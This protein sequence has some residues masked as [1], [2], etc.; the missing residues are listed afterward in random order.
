M[1]RWLCQPSRS[2]ASPRQL[3]RVRMAIITTTNIPVDIPN[4][5]SWMSSPK[6]PLSTA[7]TAVRGERQDRFPV[8]SLPIETTAI[9]QI[10]GGLY[11][12]RRQQTF[13]LRVLYR[14]SHGGDGP[15]I[16]RKSVQIIE[17][18]QGK[19]IQGCYRKSAAGP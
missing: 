15:W 10:R 6:T 14:I 2:F 1:K 17:T 5:R 12:R 18:A 4:K 13:S 7:A 3:P 9:L 11:H 8:E 19:K 16:H